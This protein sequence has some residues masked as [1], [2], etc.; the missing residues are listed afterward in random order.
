MRT[1]A[2]LM[3][4]GVLG[5]CSARETGDEV[6][7]SGGGTSR[8]YAARDFTGLLLKGGDDVDV[9]VGTGFSV[10]AEGPGGELDTLRIARDGD[11][12]VIGR[13]QRTLIGWS[14]RKDAVKVYVTMPRLAAATLAGSGTMA[15]DRI[16]GGSFEGTLA[17]S[18]D[19]NIAALATDAATLSIAGSGDVH[20][21]GAIKQLRVSIAGSGSLDAAG[22]KAQS[23]EVSIAGS[24]DV[25]A[26]VAGDAKVN[27]IGSGDVTLGASARCRVSKLGSGTVQCGS[28]ATER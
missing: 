28:M 13:R 26:S 17:G 22:L 3:M 19:L 25:R 12:L 9:R 10:R 14:S 5:A 8:T 2:I 20:A 1:V 21:G 7:A 11:T 24:G 27:M 18:G 6:A 16:E 23:A 4:A 15:V